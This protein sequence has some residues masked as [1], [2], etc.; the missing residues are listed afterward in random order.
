MEAERTIYSP[1]EVQQEAHDCQGSDVQ[2][3]LYG[4]TAG[5]GKS[6]WLRWDP[7]ITQLYDWHGM[8]GEHTRYL[9]ARAR[10]EEYHSVGWALHVRQNFKHLIQTIDECRNLAS[11]VDPGSRWISRDDLILFSCGYKQQFGHLEHEDSW[12][13]FDTNQYTHLEMDE[14]IQL[15]ECQFHGLRGR[16]RSTDP[17]LSKKLR[18][19]L[20]SNPDAPARGR[21]VKQRFVDPA[22][23]GRKML[24]EQ[25]TRFDGT[26]GTRTRM[27]IPAFLS[28]N[29]DKEFCRQYEDTLRTMPKHIM[30][31]RLF[32]KWDVIE[33]AFFEQE[34]KPSVHVVKPF[35]VPDHWPKFRI[36]DWGYK[37]PCPVYWVAVNED[38]DLVFFREVTFNHNVPASKRKDS[39][40]VAISIRNIEKEMGLWD[41][42]RN[43]SKITGPADSQIWGQIDGGWRIVDKFAAEGVHW[44]PCTKN[45]FAGTA[46]V[47][48]R[49]NDIPKSGDARPGLQVFETCTELR[50]TIP[51]LPTD[52]ND[53]E[54]P[55]DGGEDHWY[56]CLMYG[57]MYRTRAASKQP[58]KHIDECDMNDLDRARLVRQGRRWGYGT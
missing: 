41:E 33:G 51:L 31:A 25:F 43:C 15:F 18:I 55:Q 40:L 7:I 57:C 30:E 38:G 9:H 35:P 19:C 6:V 56:D 13:A 5:C 45:R 49:M 4:G 58:K 44:V 23:G 28:D 12:R 16:V 24:S 32:C 46:E 21:W 1:S 17:I 52:P 2:E 48:R 3:I 14:A 50:R 22:P 10:G 11:I 34:W 42:K 47:V 54:V 27:Y 36:M 37:S 53:P 29:P 8:P 20:A 39:Q 26:I